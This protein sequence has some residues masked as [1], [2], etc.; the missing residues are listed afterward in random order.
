MFEWINPPLHFSA[1]V[2]T[3]DRIEHAEA[4]LHGAIRL[5]QQLVGW[6]AALQQSVRVFALYLE[7]ERGRA[8]MRK[9]LASAVW[10]V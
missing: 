5:I 10:T 9:R 1:R 4:L 3:F 6:L 7:H 8:A 2:E